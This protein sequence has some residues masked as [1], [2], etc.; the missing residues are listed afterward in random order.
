MSQWLGRAVWPDDPF[1]HVYLLRAIDMI[2]AAKF[3][4]QWR[5]PPQPT[6]ETA[7]AA[8]EIDRAW[9]ASEEFLTVSRLVA[10]SCA[11]GKLEAIRRDGTQIVAMDADEWLLEH[12]R[13]G[14]ACFRTGHV[15]LPD[16]AVPVFLRLGKLEKFISGLALP[17]APEEPKQPAPADT[18]PT[19]S[20]APTSPPRGAKPKS[21]WLDVKKHVFELLDY[22]GPPSSDDPELPNQ[23]AVERRVADFLQE[24]G[25]T[26]AES[27]LRTHVSA[28][29]EDWKADK[30]DK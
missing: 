13:E 10:D 22:Y 20:T 5:P 29:I 24:R 8:A 1:G 16:K 17:V 26:A 3:G 15:F 25:L 27:T 12:S 28:Y 7:V 14:D 6:E 30:A 4:E 9:V 21:F 2:G 11:A 19:P 23:A 18:E